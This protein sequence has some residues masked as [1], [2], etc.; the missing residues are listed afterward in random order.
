MDVQILREG[1]TPVAARRP[2]HT[3]TFCFLV[4][5]GMILLEL[6]FGMNSHAG[7]WELEITE[8]SD[9]DRSVRRAHVLLPRCTFLSFI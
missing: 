4:T 1:R 5:V 2:V 6:E 3:V 7:A 9:I 8:V